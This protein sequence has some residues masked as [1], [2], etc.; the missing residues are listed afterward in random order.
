MSLPQIVAHRG[1]AAD[2]PENA[3]SSFVA[4]AESGADQIELDVHLSADNELVV[5][6]DAMLEETTLG[7]GPV[8]ALPL[9]QLQEIR[10]RGMEETIPTLAGVLDAVGNRIHT[11]IEIKRNAMGQDYEGLAER[12]IDAVESRGLKDRVTIMCFQQNSLLPFARRGYETSLSFS[13]NFGS[14]KDLKGL[15]T[16]LADAGISDIGYFFHELHD[17][18][19][20]TIHNAGLTVGVWTVNGLPRLDYW[21]RQPISYILTDQAEMALRL[22]AAM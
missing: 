12:I 19:I 4:A 6:H 15:V 1:S 8:S 5:I 22:R 17:A 3:L 20:E 13:R 9:A 14:E 2:R 7:T 18:D 11:R 16:K 21:L 10:L